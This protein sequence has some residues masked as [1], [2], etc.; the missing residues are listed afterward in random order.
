MQHIAVG[1]ESRTVIEKSHMAV[2]A[3]WCVSAK[4][5]LLPTGPSGRGEVCR[6]QPECQAVSRC[7]MTYTRILTQDHNAQ[8]GGV[9]MSIRLMCH[10]FAVV[11]VDA[12]IAHAEKN[13]RHYVEDAGES[14]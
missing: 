1:I 11:L 12:E 5:S 8:Q 7:R 4:L 2:V 13:H 10:F 3:V 14:R 9:C 6:T